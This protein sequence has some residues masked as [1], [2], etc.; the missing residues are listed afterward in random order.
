MRT[1]YKQWAVDYLDEHPEIVINKLNFEDS[2][3]IDKELCIEIGS[4]KGDFITTLALKNPNK[5]FIAVE[6]VRTIAGMLA[7]KAVDL[8]V[9]NLKVFPNDFQLTGDV[10]PN[11]SFDVIYLN[12]VDPWPKKR[13]EKRRLTYPKFIEQYYRI[14]KKNGKLIFKSDNDGLYE[15]SVEQF[16]NSKFKVLKKE[17]DYEIDLENDAM[18]EY[19]AK[20]RSKNQKIHRIVVL[21][22]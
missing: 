4:G 19:E 13:H 9:N 1:K 20:F 8:K 21:K 14:L 2:F 17:F 16:E 5:N 10:I 18:T 3:F 6:R 11:E 15:Y 22:D 12:F 7:K